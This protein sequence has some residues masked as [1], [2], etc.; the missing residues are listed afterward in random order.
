[1][2][3]LHLAY[4]IAASPLLLHCPQGSI[5]SLCDKWNPLLPAFLSS[6]VPSGAARLI[7]AD[8]QMHSAG[9]TSLTSHTLW[10]APPSGQRVN[11][12]ASKNV[13]CAYARMPS[14]NNPSCNS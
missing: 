7:E 5:G 11:K 12:P 9:P 6:S 10:N 1:M 13:F 3:P 8:S 4:L 14:L 2:I